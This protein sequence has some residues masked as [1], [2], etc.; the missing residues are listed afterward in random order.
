MCVSGRAVFS[1]S[2]LPHGIMPKKGSRAECVI[3]STGRLAAFAFTFVSESLR[4]IW[5][6]EHKPC[7]VDVYLNSKDSTAR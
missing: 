1:E 7:D 6:K 2:R 5:V 4:G 3:D